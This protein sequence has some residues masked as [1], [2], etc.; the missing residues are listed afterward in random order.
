MAQHVGV[1][2]FSESVFCGFERRRARGLAF[3]AAHDFGGLLY[4]VKVIR[5]G[6]GFRRA[7][8]PDELAAAFGAKLPRAV[9]SAQTLNH[10]RPRSDLRNQKAGGRVHSGFHHLRGDDYLAGG[11]QPGARQRGAAQYLFPV[12]RAKARVQKPNSRIEVVF[13]TE[14]A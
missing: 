2:D 12:F 10:R 7:V 1:L 14:H 3:E 9:A 11:G 13:A 6:F 5:R 4:V 8:Q